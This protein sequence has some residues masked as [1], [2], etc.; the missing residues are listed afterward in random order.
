[1]SLE[2]IYQ[3]NA[4]IAQWFSHLGAW[5]VLNVALY[6]LG[7]TLARHCSPS[8]VSEK[9]GMLGKPTTVQRRL[10]RFIDNTRV[11]VRLS[12][13][14]WSRWL[15]GQVRQGRVILLVDETRLGQHLSVMM[16]GLAYR[17][18]C[19]PLAWW[20]YHEDAWPMKQVDLI[21]ELLTW[22]AAG[23]P[24][25]CIPLVQADRGIGTSPA[26]VHVVR[27][28]GWHFLFRVQKGT[29]FRT[30]QGKQHRMADLV[31]PG[32]CWSGRGE[33]FKKAG[34]LPVTVHLIWQAGYAEPWCLITSD[35]T[36]SGH[37]YAAR[38]WQE[39]GFRDLKSD[40]WQWQATHIF[41][42]DH[43]DRLV[44]V[45]ALAYAL[46][47]TAGALALSDPVSYPVHKSSHFK[48]P[49]SLFRLGL[50]LLDFLHQQAFQLAL[51]AFNATRSC[52]DTYL[53]PPHCLKTVGA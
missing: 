27:G 18:C 7:I 42:P 44:L 36:L 38:Y 25:G 14:A 31:K 50:R 17:G 30:P 35:Q 1:M 49:F 29:C 3:W 9:L 45:M 19:I 26:L 32:E 52:L 39:A 51:S 15:I 24:A 6:S 37:L 5:Q 48:T 2:Q 13:Q 11:D 21:H 20:C 28:L 22:V 23:V 16:V 4:Q 40:G 47:L 46:T 12:C 10:E 34:W 43:A 41:T 8:R 33:V 53:P